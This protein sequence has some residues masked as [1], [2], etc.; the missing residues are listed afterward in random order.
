V[1]VSRAGLAGQKDKATL[2]QSDKQ[3]GNVQ[4]LVADGHLT[5]RSATS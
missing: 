3:F 4:V 5:Y 2:N 1:T